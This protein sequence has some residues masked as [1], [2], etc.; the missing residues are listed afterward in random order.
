MMRC[1]FRQSRAVIAMLAIPLAAL[2]IG[3]GV[4]GALHHHA[5]GARD[6]N[7]ALCTASAN[8]PTTVPAAVVPSAPQLQA[9]T[10]VLPAQ[11]ATAC[12]AGR[13]ASSRAPPTV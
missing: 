1:F 13:W 7:C 3:A 5:G 10:I 12:N 8:T 11:Q 4:L 6:A 2:L 9:G